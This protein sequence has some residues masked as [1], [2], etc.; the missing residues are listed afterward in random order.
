MTNLQ[1]F[2]A[3][4]IKVWP[5]WLTLAGCLIGPGLVEA[6]EEKWDRKNDRS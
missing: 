2:I 4:L 6:V 5:L 3:G 1:L